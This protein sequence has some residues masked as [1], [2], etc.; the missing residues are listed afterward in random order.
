MSILVPFKTIHQD[1]SYFYKS[2]RL[3]FPWVP[4]YLNKFNKTFTNIHSI[5][6]LKST[7]NAL[8]I[9]T[10]FLAMIYKNEQPR[11]TSLI[12]GRTMLENDLIYI[13]V[14]RYSN[15]VIQA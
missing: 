7:K 8:L 6:I 9:I 12:R 2:S 4:F 15:D 14:T 3:S 11:F 10:D 13:H 1:N 5:Y